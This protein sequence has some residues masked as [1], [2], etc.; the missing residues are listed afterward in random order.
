MKQIKLLF[1][2]L[3]SL[4]LPSCVS[5]TSQTP[6][7]ELHSNT[8]RLSEKI[9]VTG[10]QDSSSP[11]FPASNQTSESSGDASRVY[12]PQSTSIVPADDN[13]KQEESFVQEAVPSKE[14]LATFQTKVYTKTKARQKNL[15]IVCEKLTGTIVAPQEEFSYNTTCGPY[16]KENGFGKATIFVGKKEV[17]EYGGGVCQL[18]ST[19]YNAVKDLNVK[20]TER[21]QHSKK[22]YYVPKGKDATVS[23]GSLD[24]K[25]QNLNSYSLLLEA[26]SSAESVIVNVYKI[27]S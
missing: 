5:Q 15:Q 8:A 6:E 16:T 3:L 26:T 4:L 7:E 11:R 20:I 25:F 17:Q 27:E 23:Y 2:A 19:L 24:F 10:E 22:V 21:H 9:P 13:P 18:S 12:A 14:L 1:V